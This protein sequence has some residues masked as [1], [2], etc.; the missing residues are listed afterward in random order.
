[1]AY[2]DG[3]IKAVLFDCD[4]VLADSEGLIHAIERAELAALGLE[5]ESQAYMTRFMGMGGAE[6]YAQ[7]E[8]DALQRLGRSIRHAAKA[9]IDA[10]I[11]AAFDA[12]LREV[13]GAFAATEALRLPK[14]VASS[15]GVAALAYKL[16]KIGLWDSFAP[17]I[18]SGEQV[19]RAKPAPDLFLLAANRLDIPPAKCLV[20]EDSVN[21]V[22]AGVAAGM[23][24]W[25]FTGGAHS[26]ASIGDELANAGAERIVA[27]WP[28]AQVLFEAL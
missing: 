2:R 14:A 11:A 7:I 3:M 23:H 24:V 8:A 21:G 1:M 25:G 16:R 6:F 15:S 26:A 18:Y 9:S 28:E 17:H 20:I 10:K 27:G 19:A 5:Y 4:G 12:E 22:R 13:P